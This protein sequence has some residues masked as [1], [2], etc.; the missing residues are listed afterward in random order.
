MKKMIV[1]GLLGAACFT[2][3][4]VILR[5][6]LMT[7]M[8][9]N[10]HLYLWMSTGWALWLWP[11]FSAGLFEESG[12]YLMRRFFPTIL[13]PHPVF[14]GLG[15]G[16]AE[17]FFLLKWGWWSSYQWIE[18]PAAVL[19]HIAQTLLIWTGFKKKKA[20]PALLIAIG[21]HTT[22]NLF[23][24]FLHADIIVIE[25]AL[26]SAALLEFLGM[27][28]CYQKTEHKNHI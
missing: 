1:S 20:L 18:R 21:L 12:R 26:L 7:L 8:Q 5:L 22:F 14:F 27:L 4:Q 10:V 23:N 19:F 6:P 15:H 24:V 16:L 2:I 17:V 11:A 3:S 25:I 13:R 9:K 28:Y